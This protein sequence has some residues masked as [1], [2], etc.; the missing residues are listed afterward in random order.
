MFFFIL[1][2]DDDDIYTGEDEE[3][4]PA[5][6][7][8]CNPNEFRC[9][10]EG[11]CLPM[12]KYCDGIKHC[13]DGS[14]ED[15]KIT[16]NAT[17]IP[18]LDCAKK[19]GLF[20]CDDTCFPL[21]KICDGARDCLEGEDEE[22]CDKRQRV[23]QVVQIGVNE[24]LL[25]STSFQVYWWISVHQNLTFDYLPSIYIKGIWNNHTEW[26]KQTEFRFSN[27]DPYTL[28]N[29]TVYV[30]IAGTKL[31]FPPYRFYEVATAE[32][33]ERIYNVALNIHFK[34]LTCINFYVFY[35]SF[36]ANQCFSCA[37]KWNKDSSQL[38]TT[39]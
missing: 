28:Y 20:A 37:N 18:N 33:G 29:V 32:G 25:N 34:L 23:Y 31:E 4:C 3:N 39:A 5:Q 36:R 10:L 27:L 7:P 35:S 1:Y 9:R 17:H 16:K 38:V 11:N 12:E 30:R 8:I 21:M 26:I 19:P 6:R 22:N 2:N 14:D 15:C 24:R 13:A